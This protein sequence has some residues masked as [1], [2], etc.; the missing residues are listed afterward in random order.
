MGFMMKA[1]IFCGGRS[2]RLKEEREY[3]P[4]PFLEISSKSLL[5]HIANYYESYGFN[6]LILF[7]N[8]KINTIKDYF[9]YPNF[10]KNL[11]NLK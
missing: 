3:K 2:T 1:F 6:F 9:L 4:R 7:L 8:Y 10:T 11:K 5:G